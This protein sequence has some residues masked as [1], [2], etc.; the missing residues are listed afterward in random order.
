MSYDTT[1]RLGSDIERQKMMIFCILL[2]RKKFNEM[3]TDLIVRDV[4]ENEHNEYIKKYTYDAG[5]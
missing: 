4:Y 1:W 5:V 3:R 2:E